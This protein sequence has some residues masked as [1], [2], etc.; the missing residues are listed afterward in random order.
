[1]L[2]LEPDVALRQVLTEAL[3]ELGLEVLPVEARKQALELLLADPDLDLMLVDLVG[4]SAGGK[5]LLSFVDEQPELAAIP[6]VVMTD[7]VAPMSVPPDAASIVKPFGI[8][9]LRAAVFEAMGRSPQRIAAEPHHRV[10]T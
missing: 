6:V 7:G 5:P 4:E 10:D 8:D 9:A 3:A 1:M 2:L